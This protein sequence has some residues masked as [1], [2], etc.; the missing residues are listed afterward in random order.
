MKKLS[1]LCLA[2]LAGGLA[3]SAPAAAQETLTV[4]SFGGAYG[5]AQQVHQID[6]YMKATGN[7]VLFENYTGGVAEIKAQVQSGNIQW[8][9]VDI[10]TIDLERACSEGLLEPIPRDILEPAPNGTAAEEDFIPDALSNECGVGEIV[11]STV[12][13][14]NHDTLTGDK[15]A[16]MQ[17]FFDLKKFPGKRAL[18]KRPQVNL[19]WALLADGVPADKVYEVLATPEG[20]AQAFAK[21]DSI[22]HE[23]V[24]FDS[25]SQAPQL[26]NDGGAV[27]VQSANGRF[28]DA[29]RRENKPFTIVWDGHLYDLDAWG[30]VKGTP[31]LKQ[32]LE[33]VAFTTTTKALSGFQDV[34]YGPPRKSSMELV[35]KDVVDHLPTAHLDAGLKADGIFWADYGENLGEKF[36]EWLLK[37]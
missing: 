9:V 25:W 12:F 6:P 29:I 17:D 19:E 33:F 36:N 20:Q 28:F 5:A 15:P 14:Y 8:D 21:L 26:L 37:Q 1:T 10:E 18:R 32:A 3:A 34:A 24:W 23:I 2:V 27:F 11:W 22:K 30:I 31:K 7:K 16:T 13:A 35:D 4:V